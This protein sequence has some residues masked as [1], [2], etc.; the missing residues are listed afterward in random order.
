M[1]QTSREN[2]WRRKGK[3]KQENKGEEETGEGGEREKKKQRKRDSIFSLR[4]TEFGPS[5]F[6][7]S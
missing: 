2:R 3:N 6:V 1:E 7:G 5:V 4:Y